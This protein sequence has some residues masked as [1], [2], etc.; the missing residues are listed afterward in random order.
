MSSV[1]LHWLS[2]SSLSDETDRHQMIAGNEIIDEQDHTRA[3]SFFARPGVIITGYASGSVIAQYLS[4]DMTHRFNIEAVEAA[5][6][7]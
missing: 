4:I 5:R 3:I 2:L 6:E 7:R 1:K